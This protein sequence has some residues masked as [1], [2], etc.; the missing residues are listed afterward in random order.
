MRFF[1]CVFSNEAI[2]RIDEYSTTLVVEHISSEHS[3]N[4]TCIATNVAGTEY[5]TVPVTVN[6]PPKWILQPKDSSVQAGEDISLHCQADGYP[7]PII[8]WRKF[9][10]SFIFNLSTLLIYLDYYELGKAIGATPGEYKELLHEPNISFNNNGSLNFKKI[11]KDSQGHFL[12]E[13]K[14]NIG[15]G[16]SKVIFLKVNGNGF[17]ILYFNT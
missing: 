8:T 13:A 16:V 14:N 3:G 1:L 9:L 5:F 17:T 7:T 15:A 6:V 12:C 10:I 11:T 4:Y 2:R